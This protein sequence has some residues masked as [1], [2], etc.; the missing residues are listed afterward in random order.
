MECGGGTYI[1]SLIRD[2][3]YELNTVAT[4]TYLRRTKQGQFTLADCLT[5]DQWNADAIYDAI[6]ATNEWLQQD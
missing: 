6:D 3:G 5:Q 2:I 4:T 1:R